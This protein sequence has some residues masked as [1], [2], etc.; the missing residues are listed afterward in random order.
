M[1]CSA[2]FDAEGPE[3]TPGTPAL[4]EVAFLVGGEGVER[5]ELAE[6]WQAITEIGFRPVL[7]STRPG[8]VRGFDHLD[9]VEDFVVDR[10]VDHV[11][12]M[13]FAALVIPGGV[14][15]CDQLRTSRSA[16][17]FVRRFFEV[18]KPVAAICHAPWTLAE[19]AAL[20]GRRLT[21]WPSLKTDVTN[22]GGEW[23]DEPVVVC[24]RGSN[25][26]ITSRG[27]DDL[28]LFCG[29]LARELK[30]AGTDTDLRV[31]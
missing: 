21:G 23:V 16:V 9:P 11:D 6:P 2:V 27:P 8:V 13:D 1:L 14:I 7:V 10:V 18:G 30:R 12:A 28:L 15:N 19:A 22:A 31:S 3:E 25:T 4:N 17:A 20:T 24:R 26:L 5:I 29:A